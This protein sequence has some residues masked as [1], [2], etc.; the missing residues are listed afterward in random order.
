MCA[1]FIDYLGCALFLQA[2]LVALLHQLVSAPPLLGL[3]LK[4]GLPLFDL[5]RSCGFA[6][7]CLACDSAFELLNVPTPFVG[8][9]YGCRSV[10][11]PVSRSQLLL[12]LFY[13]P[14]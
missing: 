9:S 2:S 1:F 11:L 8:N 7:C 14:A 4:G 10:T 3:T 12:L 6:V 13:Q 5:A